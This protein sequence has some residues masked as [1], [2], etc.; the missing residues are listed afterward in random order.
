M[1][2]VISSGSWEENVVIKECTER[3]WGVAIFS[4]RVHGDFMGV[5]NIIICPKY[6]SECYVLSTHMVFSYK[7]KN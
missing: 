6:T 4:L 1:G 3:F 7:K 5:H 2:R